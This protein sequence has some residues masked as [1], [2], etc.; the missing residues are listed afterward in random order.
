MGTLFGTKG[1]AV[2][3]IQAALAKAGVVT[4]VVVEP[5][6]AELWNFTEGTLSVAWSLD[7]TP[8]EMVV[9][10]S[11]TSTSSKFSFIPSIFCSFSNFS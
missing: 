7:C 4:G 10:V 3:F 8:G 11:L 6:I 1:R 2:G 5:T 9:E